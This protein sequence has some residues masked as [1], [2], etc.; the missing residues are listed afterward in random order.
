MSA[1]SLAVFLKGRIETRLKIEQFVEDGPR[2][3]DKFYAFGVLVD[4]VDFVFV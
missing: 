2:D 3:S 1:E 4:I